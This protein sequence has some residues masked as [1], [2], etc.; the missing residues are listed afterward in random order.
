MKVQDVMTQPAHT[1]T[2]NMDLA[3]AGRRMN[4]TGCG[5]LVVLNK[6]RLAGILTDRDL[7]LSMGKVG[8][9]TRLTVGKWVDV[10]R[11]P[12]DPSVN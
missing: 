11:M 5:T 1:C 8:D 7:A 10:E 6:G 4:Y 12:E 3:A 9:P 2:I